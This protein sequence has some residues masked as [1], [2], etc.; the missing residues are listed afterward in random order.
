V[1]TYSPIKTYTNIVPTDLMAPELAKRPYF[2]LQRE[3]NSC[4]A[5]VAPQLAEAILDRARAPPKKV[6]SFGQA[7]GERGI[8]GNFGAASVRVMD[9]R[10][11][12]Q[13]GF[14]QFWNDLWQKEKAPY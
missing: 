4:F 13:Y 12:K 1:Y 2:N 8:L 14:R 10:T 5:D 7:L 11:T 3:L 6:D 9:E